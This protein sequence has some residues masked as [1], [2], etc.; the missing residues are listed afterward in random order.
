MQAYRYTAML[1]MITGGALSP[2]K[3]ITATIK[4]EESIAT[5][6]SMNDFSTPGVTVIAEF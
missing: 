6:M 3:L 5:L 1:E 4:L 2:E